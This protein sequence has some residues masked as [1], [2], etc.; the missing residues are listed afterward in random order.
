M[1]VRLYP[2][3]D[4]ESVFLSFLAQFSSGENREMLAEVLKEKTN[5]FLHFS[6]H[7]SSRLDP[8]QLEKELVFGRRA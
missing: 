7:L 3:E 2:E 6:V 4:I 5:I 1:S 8:S